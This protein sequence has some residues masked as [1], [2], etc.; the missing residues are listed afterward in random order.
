MWKYMAGA[1]AALVAT[2]V[3]T[4]VAFGHAVNSALK[5]EDEDYHDDGEL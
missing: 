5:T 4:L 3:G 1:A 2:S